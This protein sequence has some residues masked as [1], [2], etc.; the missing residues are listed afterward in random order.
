LKLNE[1][2]VHIGEVKVARHGEI[3]KTILGSCVGIGFLWESKSICGL[4]HCLL[5]EAPSKT[6]EIGGRFVTQ[7]IPS[8]IALMKIKPE[9]IQDLVVIVA[10]GGNMTQSNSKK[11]DSLVGTHNFATAEREL[12]KLGFRKLQLYKANEEGRRII[13]DSK[14]C[15]YEIEIIPRIVQAI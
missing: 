5:P 2:N 7:A 3:L 15:K 14:L 8:L 1:I 6:A 13:I 10:G 4:A 9:D 12:K 11:M